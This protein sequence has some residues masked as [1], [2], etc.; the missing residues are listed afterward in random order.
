MAG[1][2][3][4]REKTMHDPK[5]LSSYQVI[6]AAARSSAAPD[7]CISASMEREYCDRLYVW[8]SESNTRE[9]CLSKSSDRMFKRI[10]LEK[11][12]ILTTGFSKY[13]F[14]EMLWACTWPLHP[15]IES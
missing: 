5:I 1:H 15:A 13:D 12:T 3:F 8:N 4:L 10:R 7:Q 6:S 11:T 14:I 9:K 2:M